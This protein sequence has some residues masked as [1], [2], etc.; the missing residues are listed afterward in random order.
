VGAFVEAA[1][2]AIGCDAS[3]IALPL[4][5]CLARAIGNRRVI[6]LKR[7]WHEPAVIWSTIVGKSGSH[8][9]PA[10]QAATAFL[11]RQQHKA[12]K[13]FKQEMAAFPAKKET[14]EKEYRDWQSSDKSQP[15]PRRPK[16]PVCERFL[17]TDC[18]IEAMASLLN[19]QFDGLTVIRDELAGWLGG[20][21][22]YK[23]GKGSDLGHWLAFWSAA[24]FT[25][26]RKTGEPRMIHVPRASVSLTGGIQP[27]VLRKAI[28]NEHM[29]DGLCARLLLAMPDHKPVSWTDAIVDPD[30]ENLITRI[31]EHLAQL[32]PVKDDCGELQAT[33]MPLSDGAKRV[34]V[35]Y[36][37]RHRAEISELDDDLAAAWS[38]LEAYTARFALIFQLC[39]WAAGEELATDSIIDE[40]AMIDAIKVSE[41]FGREARRVYSLFHESD[42]DRELRQHSEW[43]LRQGGR[44]TVPAFQRGRRFETAKDAETALNDLK[45]A[46]YG[47]WEIVQTATKPRRDFVLTQTAMF[48]NL[49]ESREIRGFVNI[50]GVDSHGPSLNG[51]RPESN[52]YLGGERFDAF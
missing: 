41:W 15:P 35:E 44:I 20:M 25:N 43:I 39:S 46:G 33:V 28:G 49:P 1:S 14:Y 48:T 8:K 51:Y 18:T 52:E 10:L 19:S 34:W 31:F 11:N 4:L 16:T 26:D 50:N 12:I 13:K 9:T 40:S 22:E 23:G 2:T 38:K 30:A 7:T 45:R 17:T 29:K 37:N 36:F 42:L 5:A 21:G 24:P 27:E 3:F 47:D 6:R 32:Q